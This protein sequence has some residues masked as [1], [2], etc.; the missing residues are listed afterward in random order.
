MESS[1]GAEPKIAFFQIP[2]RQRAFP[3]TSEGE[4]DHRKDKL[5]ILVTG[6]LGFIGGHVVELLSAQLPAAKITVLDKFTYAALP[7]TVTRVW[8]LDNC[9]VVPCD[10]CD[11]KRLSEIFAEQA[12]DIILHLAAE[13][14][15]DNSYGNSTDFT[16]ANVFGTHGLLEAWRFSKHKDALK[17]FVHVSTDE[18]HGTVGPDHESHAHIKDALLLPTNPYAASKAAAEM[19]IHAYQSSFGLPAVITRGNNVYGPRQHTEKLI[20]RT[21]SRLLRGERPEIHGSG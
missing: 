8:E 20:P 17:L 19:Y 15:V 12:F 2:N 3:I 10:L 13:S 18:V 5:S 21:F 7:A 9:T 4:D 14:H 1:I 6:G 16:T 11:A